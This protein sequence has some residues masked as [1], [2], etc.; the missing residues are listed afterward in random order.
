MK[1]TNPAYKL[2]LVSIFVLLVALMHISY[3]GIQMQIQMSNGRRLADSTILYS[4]HTNSD[5]DILILGDSLAYGV[6]TSSPEN[7]FAG[8]IG[9]IYPDHNIINKA[10]IGDATRQLADSI[11][12]QMDRQYDV[13]FVF[14]GGNDIVRHGIDLQASEANLKKIIEVAAENSN[15]VYVLTTADFANVSI[16]PWFLAGFYSNRS[17]TLRRASQEIANR[18]GNVDYVDV[19]NFDPGT[20]KTL[21]ASD[22]FH[23]NDEGIRQLLNTVFNKQ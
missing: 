15:Q 13:T 18:Y 5:K 2:Y 14:T 11:L 17:D 10:V 23:L 7:S 3:I 12:E 22:G 4:R 21:E 20:Y 6:G 1:I 19:F 16:I 8:Q 9:A